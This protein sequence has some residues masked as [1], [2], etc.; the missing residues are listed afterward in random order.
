MRALRGYD[1]RPPNPR[2]PGGALD[3]ILSHIVARGGAWIA[4]RDQIA[5]HWLALPA[6][7]R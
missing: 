7:G 2:W 5:G 1:S 6:D 3:T 4:R